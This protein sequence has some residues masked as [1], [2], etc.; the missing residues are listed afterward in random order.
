MSLWTLVNVDDEGSIDRTSHDIAEKIPAE[1]KLELETELK[2]A[3]LEK[4][5]AEVEANIKAKSDIIQTAIEWTAKVDITDIEAEADKVIATAESIS[6]AWSAT[7]DSISA[8]YGA[9]DPDMSHRE[10]RSIT[11]RIDQELDQRDRLLDMQEDLVNSQ[12]AYMD[13]KTQAL[14]DN[15]GLIQIDGA[16]LQPHLE[17]FMWEILSAIQTRVN[18]EGLDMLTGT[19]TVTAA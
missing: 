19:P 3:Q 1:K 14:K 4:E 17:A 16:G 13:A 2:I 5:M 12:T 18:E 15:E 11:R 6:A 7:G 9:L 10:W 8:A